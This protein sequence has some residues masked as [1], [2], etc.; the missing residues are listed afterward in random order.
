MSTDYSLNSDQIKAVEY[1][2]GPLLIVAG[3]G[4]GK[5]STL[6]EKIKHLIQTEKAK[7]EEILC[8]TF[9]EKA[10]YEM[11]ERVDRAMPYGYFQ[12]WISTFHGFA[13]D[14]LKEKINHIGLNPAYDLLTQ[15]QTI[16]FFRKN[17][18]QFKLKYFR[19][20]SNPTKFIEGLLQ[21]F[22]RLQDEDISPE[23]YLKWAIK[24]Q[25]NHD[26]LPED[27]E[28]HME[29]AQA[30]ETYQRIKIEND[31]MDFGDL[32][33]YLLKLFHD[34]PNVLAEYRKQFKYVMVDEFQDT[35]IAQYQLIKLLSPFSLNPKLTV[36]GDDSQAIYKFRGASIS[37]ILTF[38]EDYQNAHQISLLQNYRSNQTVLDHAYKLIQFNNPD[39]LESKLGISKELK[40]N[41][42][43]IKESVHFELFE[44]GDTEASWVAKTIQEQIKK[45]KYEYK[46]FAIL[47][48]A[49]NHS[50]P[51]ITELTR[52]GIPYQFLGPGTLFRQSEIKDLIAYLKLLTNLEDNVSLFRLLNMDYFKLD[53]QDLILLNSFAKKTSVSL[54]QSIEIYLSF[55]NENWYKIEHQS[56]RKYLP[57]LKEQTRDSLIELFTMIK[58]HIGRLSHDSATDILYYF[59]EDT[60][61]LKKLTAY[62]TEK[63]E[64]IAVNILKFLN[65]IKNIYTNNAE[66]T[67]FTIVDYIEMS[68]ELGESPIS[69][70]TD[71]AVSNAVNILTVHASK[72]LEFPVI[73]LTN[74]I[75]GRF[76]TTNRKDTIP[77]PDELIKEQLPQG[78]YHIQEERRLFYVGLTRAMDRAFLSASEIYGDGKR[79]RKVSPFV[80][81]TIGKEVIENKLSIKKEAQEQLSIFDF[82][83][84]EEPIVKAK[85][86]VS[87][88]S[89]SQL[90]TYE[91]CPMKY[92]FQ[93]IL[94]IPTAPGS[95]ASF[96]ST[97]HNVLQQFYKGYLE[98]KSFG[99]SHMHNLVETLWD[100]AGYSSQIQAKQYK[101]E[102]KDMLEQYYKTFH[103]PEVDIL[104]LEQFFK[105]KIDEEVYLTGKID[106]VDNLANGKIE[107]IDYKT[108]KMPDEKE[109]KK[110]LQL[111]IYAMAATDKG[112]YKKEIDKVDL[113]FYYLQGTQKVTMNRTLDDVS[114]VKTK[115]E[116]IT[117]KIKS[118][119]F[120]AKVGPWCDYCDFKPIC[121][122]W[123]Q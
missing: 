93:Y 26:L 41:K 29:L 22:S 52:Q 83:K 58:R 21:H 98:D 33:Y 77:I 116:E 5:T 95:A 37:N 108:G 61:Y 101:Q 106:R 91:T 84:T 59:L 4:T 19:P 44:H 123:E 92:K 65:L 2:E 56:Y 97:I 86:N 10:A 11:E 69:A 68:Q 14:I 34:R 79:K 15:A 28:K 36:V 72:G 89:F 25:T 31:V 87:Q 8:L 24:Q 73:F 113:T 121:P 51:F 119:E 20:L 43:N 78:D 110:S 32:I 62:Q 35:N 107:I 109:L 90:E 64:K 120:P 115:I 57:L 67:V 114:A 71:A 45:N 48:R 12:M 82:K 118:G 75:N 112:L 9:T 46:D 96:G 54:Y 17:L 100:P 74:L 66:S 49:N 13:D 40:S 111:S 117:N 42:K 16:L 63:E 81:E 39:T 7:P 70:D 53:E 102:A 80:F 27:K 60:G 104:G 38:M 99:L 103:K 122:A 30:Y 105:I 85:L 1:N 55:Y 6:V 76:P 47:V 23:Q 3:A 18:F 88:F 94:K 50:E